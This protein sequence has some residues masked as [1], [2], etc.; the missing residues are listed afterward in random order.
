MQLPVHG[1]RLLYVDLGKAMFLKI[2]LELFWVKSIANL[3][4]YGV[5]KFPFGSRRATEEFNGAKQ[6]GLSECCED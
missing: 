3:T 4:V 6:G 5:P 1:N 2:E